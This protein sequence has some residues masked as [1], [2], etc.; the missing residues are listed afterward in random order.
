MKYAFEPLM[1][2]SVHHTYFSNGIF[3]D[4]AVEPDG[5]TSK[6][7]LNYGLLFKK[8]NNELHI[9]F[10]TNFNGNIRKREDVLN[11]GISCRFIIR[12]N[13]QGFYNYT[14]VGKTDINH[15]MYY[16][17]NTSKDNSVVKNTLHHDE[18]VNEKDL[19]PLDTFEDQYF[20]RPFALLDLKLAKGL[21]PSHS[22]RFKAK[23]TYWRYVLLSDDLRSLNSPAII[24]NSSAEFFEGPET[25]KFRGKDTLAFISKSPISFSQNNEKV[26]Q[27][28]DNYDEESGRY[29]VVMRALPSANP[30]HITAID[31]DTNNRN[32]NYSE[33]FIH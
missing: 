11:D 26:F 15:S 29:K 28:V 25:L 22:I 6:T 33:I 4:L 7:L 21:S 18:Y 19:F 9:L 32:L 14:E 1:S 8:H 27:L 10:D 5:P 12:L 30:D 17:R 3:R 13:D 20:I 2:I 16:F 24:S 23:E 31:G